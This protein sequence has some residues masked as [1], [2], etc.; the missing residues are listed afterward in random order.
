MASLEQIPALAATAENISVLERFLLD[1]DERAARRLSD[2]V[3]AG[4]TDLNEA[5]SARLRRE[6]SRN[7]GLC[8][9]LAQGFADVA[10]FAQEIRK[11]H[12]R[13][14]CERFDGSE[15]ASMIQK[16]LAPVVSKAREAI[17]LVPPERALPSQFEERVA[18]TFA[19]LGD[20]HFPDAI[21]LIEGLVGDM[22]ELK[23][24]LLSI[25][26]LD[27]ALGNRLELSRSRRSARTAVALS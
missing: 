24:A 20:Y 10:T 25:D 5:F 27:R 13:K 12:Q 15:P 16:K 6:Y 19:R 11:E 14:T 9:R 26:G 17:A 3:L 7:G 21:R 23:H 1:Q 18:N 4:I 22:R 8:D 2:S